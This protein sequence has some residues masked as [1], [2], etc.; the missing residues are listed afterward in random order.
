MSQSQLMDD[1]ATAIR[2]AGLACSQGRPDT[3]QLSGSWCDRLTARLAEL[4]NGF[5]VE[6]L[7]PVEADAGGIVQ[8]LEEAAWHLARTAGAWDDFITQR[9]AFD[10]VRGIR[11]P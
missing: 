10:I 9:I 2:L 3:R 8:A 4:D 7:G 6:Q 5:T 11:P 1:L